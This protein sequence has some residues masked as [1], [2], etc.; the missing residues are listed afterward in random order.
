MRELT[1]I[2]IKELGEIWL[3]I[4]TGRAINAETKARAI[5]FY[6][7]VSGTKYKASTSC[8]G[9][10]GKVFYGTEALYKEY[11]TNK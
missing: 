6:N 7:S 9:C 8:S 1:Q 4:K 11:Y 2:E 3:L 5:L 10:L